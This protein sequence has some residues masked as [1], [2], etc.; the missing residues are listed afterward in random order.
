MGNKMKKIDSIKRI[1]KNHKKEINERFRVKEIG[2]FG[3]YVRNEQK[4][5]SDLDILVEY[6]KAPS[7]FEY[8]EL[9]EYLSEILGTKIDLVTK[10]ALKPHIG[11]I[12]LEEVLYI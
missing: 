8:L 5:R 9:E 3:S 11:K 6:S 2:V 1:L 4:K 12:I 7:F 10:N